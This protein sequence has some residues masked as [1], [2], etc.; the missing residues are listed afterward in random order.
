MRLLHHLLH[1][2]P[3]R[4]RATITG[5]AAPA[6]LP[7]TCL[8]E[9]SIRTWAACLSKTKDF[10]YFMHFSLPPPPNFFSFSLKCQPP[11][12]VSPSYSRFRFCFS[13]FR[14]QG[15][16]RARLTKKGWPLNSQHSLINIHFDPRSTFKWNTESAQGTGLRWNFFIFFLTAEF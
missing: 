8:Q 10:S 7:P 14:H 9:N 13:H 12:I 6:G 11:S 1:S 2:S 16:R 4:R 5:L 15:K 3:P